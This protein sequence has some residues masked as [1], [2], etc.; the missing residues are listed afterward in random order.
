MQV[1]LINLVRPLASVLGF[2]E[3]RYK[4]ERPRRQDTEHFAVEVVAA[5]VVLHPGPLRST[6]YV[7]LVVAQAPLLGSLRYVLVLNAVDDSSLLGV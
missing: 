3:L 1:E 2:L 7:F 5:K 4:A 6:G